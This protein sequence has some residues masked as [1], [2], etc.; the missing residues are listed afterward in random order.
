LI[1]IKQKYQQNIFYP[2]SLCEEKITES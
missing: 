2:D 1:H